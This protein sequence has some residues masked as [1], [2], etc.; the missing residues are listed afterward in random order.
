MG[1]SIVREL[2]KKMRLLVGFIT[3]LLANKIPGYVG[4]SPVS[5]D[6]E[7][8][9]P[10]GCEEMASR[11]IQVEA[12]VN[13]LRQDVDKLQSSND[14][15]IERV[16]ALH[17]QVNGPVKSAS[18][19]QEHYDNGMR[20]NGMYTI[21]PTLSYDPFEVKCKFD[22]E[23]V[24][25]ELA[26]THTNWPTYTATPGGSDGCA[27]P[28]C[29]KDKITYAAN[30]DQLEALVSISH[31][32]E[33]R[34]FQNCTSNALTDFSWWVGR[35]GEQVNYW[36][37]DKE[38]TDQGCACYDS[39][40]CVSSH[41][42]PTKCNC[43]SLD[44]G[45][46]DEGLLTSMEQLPVME[47]AYGDSARRYSFIYYELGNFKCYGKKNMYPSEILV[48][49]FA[50][51]A[52]GDPGTMVESS[53]E[54][55]FN[56][57]LFDRSLGAMKKGYFIAPVEGY[58]R[59][60]MQ[61]ALKMLSTAEFGLKYQYEIEVLHN[62]KIVDFIYDNTE[63]VEARAFK[64]ISYTLEIPMKTGDTL[65][66]RTKSAFTT[67]VMTDGCSTNGESHNCSWLIGRQTHFLDDYARNL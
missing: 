4:E 14:Q 46:V 50:F 38:T 67:Y 63:G 15:L 52:A 43:D 22:G 27:D 42:Y 17:T 59:F 57:M 65:K 11:L 37:G 34:V 55:V 64:T 47:L 24:E 54:I 16:D 32:C 30:V 12:Q 5:V 9:C 20:E 49:D 7:D 36:H 33:Q 3:G 28:G 31:R 21:Q 2:R 61:L 23:E 19:C 25:T 18:S 26:R 60:D 1:Y 40:K 10:M 62:N 56:H 48:N 45:N 41:G 51:K 58:W 66:F 8:D 13:A 29:F 44:E 53:S 6:Y 39:D 35:H